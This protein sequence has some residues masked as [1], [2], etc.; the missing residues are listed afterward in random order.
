[1]KILYIATEQT[2][3]STV[4]GLGRVAYFLPKELQ[5]LGVDV[6]V[7]MPKYGKIDEKKAQMETVLH[8]L[9]VPTQEGFNDLICNVKMSKP[10]G[11]VTY[12][13]ENQEYYELRANEYGYFDDPLRFTLLCRGALEF[14]RHPQ[15][16][17]IPDV[18][19]SNDWQTSLISQMLP[20]FYAHDEKLS[21]IVTLYSIHNLAYQGMYDYRFVSD[22]DF[23][24]GKSTIPGF[25]IQDFRK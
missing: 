9:H 10:E 16:D 18:I 25:M 6:R 19:H 1:M 22:L 5:K 11:L 24:D 3:Y 12:F 17:W 20:T 8:G 14:L 7:I 21:P 13:L 15:N 4:G 2:P 23:D